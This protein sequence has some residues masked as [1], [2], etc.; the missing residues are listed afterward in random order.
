M[1]TS[2]VT[3]GPGIVFYTSLAFAACMVVALVVVFRKRK[4]EDV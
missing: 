3:P 1:E 4:K 2:V